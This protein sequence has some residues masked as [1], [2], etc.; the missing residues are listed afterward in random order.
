MAHAVTW[1]PPT[2]TEIGTVLKS[3]LAAGISWPLAQ[4]VTGVGDPV[5]AAL[6]ALVVVQVSVRASIF[7]ALQRS[8]AVVLGVLVALAIGDLLA[9][10]WLTV[11][12]LVTAALGVAELI[13]RLPPAAARQVPVSGLLVLSAAAVD[14]GRFAGLRALDTVVGAVVGVVVSLVLPA[15][16]LV[17]ARQTV[18]RLA[19]S[20]G[21]VLEAMG[22]GLAEPWT[23]AQTQEWRRTA[24]AVRGRLVGQATEA[25][26]TGRESARWNVRDRR[27]V[28]ELARYEEVLPRL[29]RTAIGASVISRGLDDHAHLPAHLPAHPPADGPGRGDDRPR[30]DRRHADR[31][32]AGRTRDDRPGDD[33]AARCRPWAT[34]WWPWRRRFAPSAVTCWTVRGPAAAGS[35]SPWPTSASSAGVACWARRAGPGWP[36]SGRRT[37]TARRRRTGR[38]G[39]ASGSTTPRSSC[40]WTASSAT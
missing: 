16:R 15:S 24:R 7:T 30:N 23:A 4:A 25:V 14:P 27:H 21:D 31:R 17:D 34:C 28:E 1:T 29:E 18:D 3:G 33:A 9:L 40:R 8:A 37:R 38:R 19:R 2:S 22:R 35:G 32:H 10:N 13:L 6:T 20:L 36:S 5:L 12:L 39:R 11:A 26:G